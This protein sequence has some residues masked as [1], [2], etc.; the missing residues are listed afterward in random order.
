MGRLAWLLEC[1]I[2]QMYSAC[3]RQSMMPKLCAQR[4][5]SLTTVMLVQDA[6]LSVNRMRM[7]YTEMVLILRR[8]Y[9]DC[10]LVHG[11]LSEY[12]ILFH[13]VR[14]IITASL[15]ILVDIANHLGVMPTS[16]QQTWRHANGGTESIMCL[17][18]MAS[19][20]QPLPGRVWCTC[21]DDAELSCACN[22]NRP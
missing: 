17:C 20:V 19:N 6:S 13:Q 16:C 7:A 3:Q 10:R 22:L 11:D 5:V 14:H 2:C 18:S 8:L 21:H 15:C 4:Q 9:Q 1:S 12:N